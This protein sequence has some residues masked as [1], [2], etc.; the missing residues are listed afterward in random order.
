[1]EKVQ[2]LEN[3]IKSIKNNEFKFFIFVQDTKGNAKASIKYLYDIGLSLKSLGYNVVMTHEKSDYSGVSNWLDSK[4]MDDLTHESIDNQ[5]LQ[6]SPSDFLIIPELF[7]FMMDQVK[8]LPCGKIVI[9][10]SY[11]YILETLNP[12]FG[13]ENYGFLKCITTSEIMKDYI[14]GIFKNVSI[15]ILEPV[16][17]SKFKKSKFPPKTIISVHSRDPRKT[18]NIIKTFYLKFPQY[19]W[20]TFRD[21]RGLSES[22]FA[23]NISDSFLSVWVDDISSYG[24]YPLESMKSGVPVLGKIPQLIPYWMNDNN[25]FWT[26]NDINLVN[27]IGEFIQAWLEDSIDENIYSEMTKTIETLP[28]QDVFNENIKTL[29]Q[30]YINTRL[31]TF[32]NKL[33]TLKD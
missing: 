32:E 21:M 18:M 22:D 31:E 4:Y 7:G 19:R 29:F 16:I 28:D 25:G 9:A 10:Q 1:M 20:I 11:D 14:S 23:K 27:L 26:D 12:G 15:D 30:S 3:A 13:W 8:D 17:S 24:T 6:V 33:K 2:N 5:N